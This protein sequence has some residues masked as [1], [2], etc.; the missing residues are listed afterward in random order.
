MKSMKTAKKRKNFKINMYGQEWEV[1]YLTPI[2]EEGHRA[3]G[4]C[5]YDSRTIYIDSTLDDELTA[6][7]FFHELFHAYC[8]RMGMINSSISHE[9][10]ELIADQFGQ[11]IAENFD[12]DF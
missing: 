8:R 1:K 5:C 6:V 7:T 10:E 9:A 2:I 4:L 12:F 11:L 3:Y